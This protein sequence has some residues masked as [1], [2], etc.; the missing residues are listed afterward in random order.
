LHR[1]KTRGHEK[2]DETNAHHPHMHSNRPFFD[3]R[4]I[5]DYSENGPGVSPKN[6]APL[7]PLVHYSQNEIASAAF[8]HRYEN[9]PQIRGVF[10]GSAQ[11]GVF[12]PQP[13]RNP[14]YLRHKNTT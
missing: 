1:D 12:S 3:H 8:P 4:T 14:P 13:P 10:L 11:R 6:R 5:S 2:Y 9:K 7:G